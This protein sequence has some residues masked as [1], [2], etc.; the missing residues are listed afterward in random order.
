MRA[1]IVPSAVTAEPGEAEA[2]NLLAEIL[3]GGA[4]SRFYDQLVRGDGPATYSGANYPQTTWTIA[5]FIDLRPAE[6]RHRPPRRWSSGW[7]R[8]LP[9]C[10]QNGITEEELE[11]AKR[12]AIAQAIYSLDNQRSL[13]NIVG[14]SL[15]IGRELEHVQEWPARIQAVTAEQVQQV[16][17]KYLRVE[18]VGHRLS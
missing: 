7:T 1:Y 16:A 11:R 8:S 17:Q 3:G 13:V 5:R 14:Q 12:S 10:R 15:T 2:M 18:V 4:T 9:I 6:A